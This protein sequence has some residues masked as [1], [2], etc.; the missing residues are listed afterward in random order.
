MSDHSFPP[1]AVVDL[2]FFALIFNVFIM[3]LGFAIVAGLANFTDA[4]GAVRGLFGPASG[5][6][7]I[8]AGLLSTVRSAIVELLTSLALPEE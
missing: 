4:G 7:V 5:F 3:A 6:L 1:R 8:I 2:V